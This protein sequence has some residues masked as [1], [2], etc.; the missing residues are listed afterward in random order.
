MNHKDINLGREDWK[1]ISRLVTIAE[2][3]ERGPYKTHKDKDR[4]HIGKY[5][6]EN[7]PKFF[8]LNDQ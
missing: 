7:C 5:A 1:H 2:N 3:K 8:N 4:Y 6:S